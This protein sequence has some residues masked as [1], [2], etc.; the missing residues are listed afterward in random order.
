MKTTV[1]FI[2][3]DNIKC[4]F[5]MGYLIAKILAAFLDVEII[6]FNFYT[7][8]END[9]RIRVPIIKQ[10]TGVEIQTP[11][12]NEWSGIECMTLNIGEKLKFKHKPIQMNRKDGVLKGEYMN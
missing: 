6:N 12:Q 7:T 10:P 3:W 8:Y 9:E 5:S 1:G 11:P 4:Q 2:T